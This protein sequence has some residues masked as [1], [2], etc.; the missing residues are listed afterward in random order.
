MMLIWTYPCVIHRYNKQFELC[1]SSS[2]PRLVF[3]CWGCKTFHGE[4]EHCHV[5]TVHLNWSNPVCE[6]TRICAQNN[7]LTTR[8]GNNIIIPLTSHHLRASN[9]PFTRGVAGVSVSHLFWSQFLVHPHYLSVHIQRVL[10][11]WITTSDRVF[12]EHIFNHRN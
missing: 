1:T 11:Y 3:P 9:H 6:S 10:P 12:G 5:C 2:F 4:E 7:V 8:I